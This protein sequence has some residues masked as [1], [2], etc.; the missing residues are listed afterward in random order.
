MNILFWVLQVLLALLLLAG[1]G[2]KVVNPNDPAKQIR[3][4]SPAAWRAIGVFEVLGAV[5]LIVPSAA[6]WMPALTPL[7]AAALALENLALAVVYARHS[8]KLVA[9]NPLVYV[10][11]IALM[12]ILVGYGR[13]ALSP[14]L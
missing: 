5:L 10:V 8:T 11:P 6:K 7:A 14:L 3:A 9:A 2:F 12:A 1:G 13:Y 4:I